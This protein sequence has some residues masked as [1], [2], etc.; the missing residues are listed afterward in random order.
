MHLHAHKRVRAPKRTKSQRKSHAPKHPQVYT[1]QIP[2]TPTHSLNYNAYCIY[3][4]PACSLL[5]IFSV[6][7]GSFT[8][9]VLQ[10]VV[11]K[12]AAVSFPAICHTTAWP[13][14]VCL[15]L[16]FVNRTSLRSEGWSVFMLV[17]DGVCLSWPES[18]YYLEVDQECALA[19]H[20][21]VT[22]KWSNKVLRLLQVL[23]EALVGEGW[24]GA[25]LRPESL[26]D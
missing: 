24:R 15:G 17:N 18:P 23:C 6:P 25:E 13:T 20:R 5:L 21:A 10:T 12:L 8:P 7:P 11:S 9:N 19:T 22:W 14:V 16:S 1:C 4:H 26:A 3:T 2:H